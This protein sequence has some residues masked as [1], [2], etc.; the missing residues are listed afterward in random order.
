MEN[1]YY[2]IPDV[3]AKYL[4]G[5]GY[6]DDIVSSEGRHGC[7]YSLA[8]PEVKIPRFTVSFVG[9]KDEMQIRVTWAPEGLKVGMYA[10]CHAITWK[11]WIRY[12]RAGVW[13]RWLQDILERM[14][15]AFF[16]RCFNLFTAEGDENR[17]VL[18]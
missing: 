13:K 6:I 10:C 5:N 12:E 2:P 9:L 8:E 11:D 16:A 4:S 17:L 1:R 7:I 14:T 15:I 3:L 18:K